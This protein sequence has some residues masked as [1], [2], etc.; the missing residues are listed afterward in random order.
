[1][2]VEQQP[3]ATDIFDQKVQEYVFSGS[4]LSP[5]EMALMEKR[6]EE[7]EKLQNRKHDDF[8]ECETNTET[9]YDSEPD[10]TDVFMM[11]GIKNPG[12]GEEVGVTDP[13]A[14]G[15]IDQ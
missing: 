10:D 11:Q 13:A 6:I 12:S 7:R 1:M 2:E 5:A 15:F 4:K 14:E 9:E 3:T 8:L